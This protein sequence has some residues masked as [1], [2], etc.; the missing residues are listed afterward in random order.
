MVKMINGV[1]YFYDFRQR[2]P[3]EP[4]AKG[5]RKQKQEQLSAKQKKKIVSKQFISSSEDNSSSDDDGLKID[6]TKG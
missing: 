5:P 6:V 1:D 2:K 4:K 3:R